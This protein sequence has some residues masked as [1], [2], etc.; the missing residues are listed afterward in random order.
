MEPFSA[1]RIRPRRADAAPRRG[2]AGPTLRRPCLS[3]RRR[4]DS[5]AGRRARK[6]WKGS[7]SIHARIRGPT[8]S[9]DRDC[10]QAFHA[11]QAL[12]ETREDLNF[13]HHEIQLLL[14]LVCAFSFTWIPVPDG[15]P[16][17][18]VSRA[19]VLMLNL[20]LLLYNQYFPSIRCFPCVKFS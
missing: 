6:V 12:N 20:N 13:E 19:G 11:F 4:N 10:P 18:V 9:A 17:S 7:W 3:Q 15:P 16:T 8:E 14:Y 2:H 1:S 5:L